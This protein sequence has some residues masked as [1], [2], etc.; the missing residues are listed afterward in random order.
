MRENLFRLKL[1]TKVLLITTVIL[2]SIQ[3]F[4]SI[5]EIAFLYNHLESNSIKKYYYV[6]NVIKQK[7][8]KSMAFGKQL[9]SLNFS[10][11]L[12]DTIPTE[13]ENFYISDSD[14]NILFKQFEEKQYSNSFLLDFTTTKNNMTYQVNIPLH[15]KSTKT[16]GNIVIIIS[17]AQIRDRLYKLIKEAVINFLIMI[18]IILPIL[19][20]ILIVYIDRP[21]TSK[22]KKITQR[23]RNKEYE[24]LDLEGI[25]LD[26]LVAAEA[27]IE[28]I[29]TGNWL[30]LDLDKNIEN[31]NSI[32]AL[33]ESM[34]QDE[35]DTL[36]EI[37][38]DWVTIKKNENSSKN[39]KK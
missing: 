16:I 1:R 22:I 15:N 9:E 20:I 10:R 32:T 28:H 11:L 31:E 12:K 6:G 36:K 35:K 18:G 34:S 23:F 7:L 27:L 21:Y 2:I 25:E 4:N 29:S 30:N 33:I 24:S 3:S 5:L 8:E 19:Y 14:E 26:N 37:I 13:V 17:N 38:R 39:G